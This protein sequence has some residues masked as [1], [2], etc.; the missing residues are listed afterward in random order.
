[1]EESVEGKATELHRK[2]VLVTGRTG[3]ERQLDRLALPFGWRQQG[4]GERGTT[5]CSSCLSKG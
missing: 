4:L 2:D 3:A 1:M 5:G